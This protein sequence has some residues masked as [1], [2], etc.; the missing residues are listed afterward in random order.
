[1][2]PQLDSTSTYGEQLIGNI[3]NNE[4]VNS[5]TPET[6]TMLDEVSEIEDL[7]VCFDSLL[8]SDKHICEKKINKAYMTFGM[9]KRN[10][11]HISR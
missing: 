7:G 6:L 11:V 2:P 1:V 9:I 5:V 3:L 4:L 8:V 10:C